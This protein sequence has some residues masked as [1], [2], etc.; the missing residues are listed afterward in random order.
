MTNYRAKELKD[1]LNNR[2]DEELMHLNDALKTIN[3]DAALGVLLTCYTDDESGNV[4]Y[5]HGWI[6]SMIE[7]RTEKNKT[8]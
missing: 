6:T 5:M 7:R 3:E 1:E 4:A 2:T 8:G